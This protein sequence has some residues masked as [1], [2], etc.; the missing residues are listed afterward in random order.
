M[1]HYD[2]NQH[3][4]WPTSTSVYLVKIINEDNPKGI[5]TTAYFNEFDQ[6][7]VYTSHIDRRVNARNK[8]YSGYDVFTQSVVAYH[9]TPV[10][11]II[12]EHSQRGIVEDYG[13]GL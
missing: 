11:E 13:R 5:I 7:N 1:K 6:W 3:T 8:E 12:E 2:N 4:T 9:S 10:D